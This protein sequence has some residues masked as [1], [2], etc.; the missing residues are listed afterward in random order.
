MNLCIELWCKRFN[1]I[2]MSKIGGKVMIKTN[3]IE[4]TEEE[5]HQEIQLKLNA[6]MNMNMI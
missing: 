6:Q 4:L 2:W 1:Y 3:L 5:D